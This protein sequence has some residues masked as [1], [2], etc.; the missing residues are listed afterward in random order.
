MKKQFFKT[1]AIK[2]YSTALITSMLALSAFT[3][4][5][6]TE[7]TENASAAQITYVGSSNSLMTF[8]VNY[9]NLAEENFV[10]ELTD[11]MGHVLF[12]KKFNDKTF[13]KNIVLKNVGDKVKVNFAIRAGKNTINQKFDIDSQTRLVEE[14]IVTKI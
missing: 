14:V 6:A 13:N 9:N 10:L 12:E 4:A 7:K 2:V 1:T 5:H 11:D 3:P 8:N